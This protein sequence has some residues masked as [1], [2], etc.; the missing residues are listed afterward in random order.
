MHAALK[1]QGL[2]VGLN[3]VARLMSENGLKARQ[4]TRFKK[5]TDSDHGGPAATDVLDQ[6][7]TATAPDQKWGVDISYIWTAEHR[8]VA[9]WCRQQVMERRPAASC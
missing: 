9:G 4:E 1:D 6:D 8:G 5:T 7:F 2:A 3:R